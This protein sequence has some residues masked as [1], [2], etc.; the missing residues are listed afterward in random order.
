MLTICIN[1]NN[2]H[3]RESIIPIITD[4]PKKSYI[5]DITYLKDIVGEKTEYPY[6]LVI[7]DHFSKLCIAYPNKDKTSIKVLNKIKEFIS[8]YGN[9]EEFSCDIGKEFSNKNLKEYMESKN[10]KLIHGR[11]YNPKSQGSVERLHQSLKKAIN[12]FHN[13]YKY[14]H[15]K[16]IIRIVCQNYNNKRHTS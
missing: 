4:H 14:I 2:R 3:K 8:Y 11:P 5:E 9:P 13:E 1:Q 7:Q 12:A 15:I 6:L 10:I 16:D